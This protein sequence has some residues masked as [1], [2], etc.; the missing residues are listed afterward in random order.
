M[1]L[2]GHS[3]DVDDTGRPFLIA[4]PGTIASE[5]RCVD[6]AQALRQ[7]ADRTGTLVIFQADLGPTHLGA[8]S[9]HHGL[10]QD[11]ALRVL[12]KVRSETGLPVLARVHDAAQVAA[13]AQVADM[14]QTPGV[15]A[16]QADLIM[17]AAASGRPVNLEKGPSMS[18]AGVARMVGMARTAAQAAGHRQDA[19]TVC[20]GGTLFGPDNLVVDMRNLIQL[21]DIGCPV[22]FDATH[23]L[24]DPVSQGGSSGA[25]REFVAPL[26][27]AAVAVGVAGLMLEIDAQPDHAPSR[28]RHGVSLPQVP[29]LAET[30]LRL[31]DCAALAAAPTPAPLFAWHRR[32]PVAV[33]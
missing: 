29:D 1:N 9:G 13:A 14:L 11:E 6:A 20:E 12:E 18:L 7:L 25:Q 2:L 16:G 8:H 28:G 19:F 30:L 24:H 21:R 15:L 26:A 33:A 3:I 31:A 23:A 32:R 5:A 17:A 4:G 22:V 10:G 27:R